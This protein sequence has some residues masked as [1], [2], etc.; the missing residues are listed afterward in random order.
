MASLPRFG[1]RNSLIIAGFVGF[2]GLALYPIVIAPIVNPK[3][4]QNVQKET[5]KGIDQASIQPGGMRVWSDPFKP[6]LD[7]LADGK[8]S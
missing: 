8:T 1:T 5:R 7:K 2:I 3:K 4:W 6:R